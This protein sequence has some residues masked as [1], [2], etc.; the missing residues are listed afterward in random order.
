MPDLR[1]GDA[2]AQLDELSAKGSRGQE[3]ALNHQRS[4]TLLQW[5]HRQCGFNG[6]MT[7]RPLVLAN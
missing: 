6:G 7:H 4:G 5:Q 1:V 2:A 3:A